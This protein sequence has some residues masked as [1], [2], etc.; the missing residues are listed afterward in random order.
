MEQLAI[1]ARLKP[2]AESRAAALIE[3]GPPFDPAESGLDRHAVYLSA[4][5]VVFVFEAREVEWIVEELVDDPF[6]WLAAEALDEWRPLVDGEPRIARPA[7]VWTR[8]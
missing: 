7:Y 6:R 8:E 5:E 1:V 3:K 2:G 4:G